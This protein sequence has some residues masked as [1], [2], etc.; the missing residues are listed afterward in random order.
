V[1]PFVIFPACTSFIT[2]NLDAKSVDALSDTSYTEYA[3]IFSGG[4]SPSPTGLP[5]SD[6]HSVSPHSPDE[7]VE[8]AYNKPS[9]KPNGVNDIFVVQN[10][11]RQSSDDKNDTFEYQELEEDK[12]PTARTP[13]PTEYALKHH[14]LDNSTFHCVSIVPSNET[15]LN[16][17][18]RLAFDIGLNGI[19][20][21]NAAATWNPPRS[22]NDLYSPRW[23]RGIGPK[24]EGLCPLCDPT[25]DVCISVHNM[26]L[27]TKTSRFW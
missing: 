20:I 4:Q 7:K 16:L 17:L 15:I 1:L 21:S 24:K 25:N 2:S 6:E 12:L 8:S 5:H 10:E 19:Q 3:A 22:P 14:S 9:H 11:Y 27:K 23:Q 18:P 13:A 26:W